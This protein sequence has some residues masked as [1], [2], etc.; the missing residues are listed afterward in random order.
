M[1]TQHVQ[2]LLQK[3]LRRLQN[4]AIRESRHGVSRTF[5]FCVAARVAP[6][7]AWLSVDAA[8]R[9]HKLT[10]SPPGPSPPRGRGEKQ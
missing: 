3:Q 4:N 7:L 6:G 9:F 8:V 10:P 1:T 2:H 5:E